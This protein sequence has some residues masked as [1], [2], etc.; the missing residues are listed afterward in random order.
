MD[1]YFKT[2]MKAPFQGGTVHPHL[3]RIPFPRVAS[4]PIPGRS[5]RDGAAW[6][7]G[8][9]QPLQGLGAKVGGWVTKEGMGGM[10]GVAWGGVNGCDGVEG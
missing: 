4:L 1:S 9:G 10:G 3:S 6:A 7:H 2:G 5:V 8:L